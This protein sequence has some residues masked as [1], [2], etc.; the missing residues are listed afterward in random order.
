MIILNS[1]DAEAKPVFEHEL[2]QNGY[3]LSIKKTT[4]IIIT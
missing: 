2:K 4:S 1:F 3:Y